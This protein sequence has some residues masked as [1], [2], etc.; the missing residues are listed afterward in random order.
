MTE[1][2]LKLFC[3]LPLI[4]WPFGD[5]GLHD[6]W[7]IINCVV[8]ANSIVALKFL[9]VL[10]KYEEIGLVVLSPLDFRPILDLPRNQSSNRLYT[11]SSQLGNACRYNSLVLLDSLLIV[12]MRNN[13]FITS[14]LDLSFTIE[15]QT[16][17]FIA[18]VIC[19][20]DSNVFLGFLQ[21]N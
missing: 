15:V 20:V 14:T 1:G 17:T 8:S 12:P 19:V 11:K 13:N 6:S 4:S 3:V 2:Y 16:A 5:N 9:G 7:L 21:T 18:L 10:L